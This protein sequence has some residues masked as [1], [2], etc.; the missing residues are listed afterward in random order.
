MPGSC[1]TLTVGPGRLALRVVSDS[2]Q[3]PVSGALVTATSLPAGY[4]PANCQGPQKTSSFTTNST[5][6]YSPSANW[7]GGFSLVVKYSGHSYSFT[8]NLP[9]ES[10]TCASLYVPSGMKNVTFAG[11]SNTCPSTI[12]T[13]STG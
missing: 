8:V 1:P 4:L 11:F 6:W 13:A 9:V 3:T 5:E 12:T 10:L 2:N 7:A